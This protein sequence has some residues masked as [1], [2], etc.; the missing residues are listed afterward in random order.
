WP[1]VPAPADPFADED[2]HL[3]LY[4][5]YELHYRGLP[6]ADER[7]E[8]EPS[9]L[10]LRARLEERFEHGLH[11]IAG[12]PAVERLAPEEMDLALRA[13]AEAD[14]APSLSRYLE[15]HGTVAQVLEFVVH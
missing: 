14:D 11:A 6:G 4:L 2:L 13:V 10:S 15:R 7:W 12:A 9:L 5:C 8:W 3:S 1:A